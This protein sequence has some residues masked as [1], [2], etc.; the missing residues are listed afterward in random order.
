MKLPEKARL[1]SVSVNGNEV[2][3][4]A[5][6]DQLCV[7]KLP[8]RDAQQAAHR[9]SFRLGYPAMRLGFIG[10]A[11]VKL[12]ELFQTAGITEWVVALPGGFQ[13]QILSSGLE[14]QKSPPNLDRFGDYGRI[15]KSRPY[16]FMAGELT[17]PGAL[18]V[19]LKY[20]QLV[21]GI[22]DAPSDSIRPAGSLT[23]A[24]SGGMGSP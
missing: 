4:P 6:T 23:T 12:P 1:V 2:T 9:I 13:T 20:H 24:A 15:L 19:S 21:P 22:L 7:V 5:V 8:P 10:T 14:P 18:G 17:P 11:D 16:N 3:S